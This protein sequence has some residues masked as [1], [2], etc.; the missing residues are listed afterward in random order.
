MASYD[1][2]RLASM[3]DN[4]ER[5]MSILEHLANETIDEF[6]NSV[7][8]EHDYFFVR[9]QMRE[10]LDK[11]DRRFELINKWQIRLDALKDV[12]KLMDA[13]TD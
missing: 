7:Q 5:Q 6:V 9:T 4:A 3:I 1:K 8:Q 12:K 10:T 11:L 2:D 13:M